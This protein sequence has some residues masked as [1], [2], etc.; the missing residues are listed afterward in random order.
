MIKVRVFLLGLIAIVAANS[1]VSAGGF[2]KARFDKGCGAESSQCES[3]CAAS[4]SA[5]TCDSGCGA[6]SPASCDSGC[7]APASGSSASGCG[8]SVSYVEKTVMVP[9]QFTEMK[10][11]TKT[12]TRQLHKSSVRLEMAAHAIRSSK[13]NPAQLRHR[14]Q[15]RPLQ[16]IKKAELGR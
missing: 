8:S 16:N 15:K 5:S 2:L 14:V 11:V 1:Q 7:G 13:P 12:L 9:Q 4:S 10:T 6:A 3:G